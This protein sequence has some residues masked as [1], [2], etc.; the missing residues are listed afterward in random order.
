MKEMEVEILE[1]HHPVGLVAGQFLGLVEVHEIVMI[2]EESDRMDSALQ[3]MMPM[4]Q[5]MNDG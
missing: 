3:I 2:H 4:F 1:E 5:G